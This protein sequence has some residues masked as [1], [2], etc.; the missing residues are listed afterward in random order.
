MPEAAIAA[1]S[2]LSSRCG[3]QNR[4]HCMRTIIEATRAGT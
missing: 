1:L 4:I 2:Q 3:A